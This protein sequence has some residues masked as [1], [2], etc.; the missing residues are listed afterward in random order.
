MDYALESFLN[1]C[2]RNKRRF[3]ETADAKVVSYLY[4]MDNCYFWREVDR[5]STIKDRKPNMSVLHAALVTSRTVT[6]HPV[7]INNSGPV[8]CPGT[9]S[10]VILVLM[11]HN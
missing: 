11:L 3:D 6:R 10:S 1:V 9:V 4:I 5:F 8:H 7:P 2:M